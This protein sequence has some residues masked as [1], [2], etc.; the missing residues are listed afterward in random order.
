[1]TPQRLTVALGVSALLTG[2]MIFTGTW[3]AAVLSWRFPNLLWLL[4]LLPLAWAVNRA[5]AIRRDARVRRFADPATLQRLIAGTSPALRRVRLVVMGAGLLLMVL[6]L[7]GPQYGSR[8]QTVRKRG[9]DLV[10]VLDFSKS[11]LARDIKPDRISRAKAELSRFFSELT[12]DR[13]GVVAFAGE[14]LEFP[15]TS[16]YAAIE[17]FLSELGPYDMPVGGTAIARALTA[18]Q[19]LLERSNSTPA[20]SESTL[21]QTRSQVIILMTDGED[22][23]GD[24][25]AAAKGLADAGIRLYTVGLGSASGEPIPTYADDGTWTGYLRDEDGR[26]V[27]TAL[28]AESEATLTSIAEATGGKYL[29][30][31]RGGVGMTKIR[32]EVQR[33]KQQEREERQVTIM[34]DRYALLLFPGFLFLLCEA[35][36]PRGSVSRRAM[37]GSGSA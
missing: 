34:E 25:A 18:G 2:L 8:T 9:V 26:P 6:S 7:A 16:D 13:V 37:A 33:M 10:V 30:A 28:T 1:M 20:G 3:L 12:G 14:T 17:L 36:L 19:R 23:E 32:Q 15:M 11:M 22:H 4:V 31:E 27:T 21:Q 29:Q 35:L 24:P 5:G